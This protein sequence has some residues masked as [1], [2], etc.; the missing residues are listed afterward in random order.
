MLKIWGRR[1]SAHTQRVLWASVEA[2]VQFDLI[3]AS[4][5]MGTDGHVSGGSRA[6]GVVETPEYRAMNPNG[7]IPTIDDDGFILWE[8]NTIS[9]YLAQ[10][11]APQALFGSDIRT[12]GRASQWMDWT[13]TQLEPAL[14][15][16]VME[17]VR[18]P[19][20]ARDPTTLEATRLGI[21]PALQRLNDHLGNRPYVAGDD[22]TIGDIAPATA[23]RRWHVFGLEAPPMPHLEDWQTRVAQREGFRLHIESP[24]LHLA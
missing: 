15:I 4:A 22:F 9:R 3:L 13:N 21:L 2:G 12:L 19:E 8:S 18:L 11:Y 5:T 20:K 17:L 7:T 10:T 1:N 14:H 24:K 16:L 6:F 23:V